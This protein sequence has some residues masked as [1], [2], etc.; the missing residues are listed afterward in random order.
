MLGQQSFC[1]NT[2]AVRRYRMCLQGTGSTVSLLC[3]AA[4]SYTGHNLSSPLSPCASASSGTPGTRP[5]EGNSAPVDTRRESTKHLT[6]NLAAACGREPRM[7]HRLNTRHSRVQQMPSKARCIDS[8]NLSFYYQKLHYWHTRTQKGWKGHHQ[9]VTWQMTARSQ[10][11]Q[12]LLKKRKEKENSTCV[13]EDF[14]N[15]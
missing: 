7:E 2:S 1:S 14:V 10:P 3:P 11:S 13:A 4:S 15:I 5:S 9:A 12:T 8:S 6:N